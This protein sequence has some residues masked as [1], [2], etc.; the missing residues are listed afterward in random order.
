VIVDTISNSSE[1]EVRLGSLFLRLAETLEPGFDLADY[2]QMLVDE[3]VGLLPADEAAL[4]LGDSSSQLGVAAATAP[5]ARAVETLVLEHGSSPCH[6]AFIK[7]VP[8]GVHD[9]SDAKE[10]WGGFARVLDAAGF[11]AVHAVPMQIRDTTIGVVSMFSRLPYTPS[12]VDAKI[13]AMIARAAAIAL[14]QARAAADHAALTDQLQQAL[15]SRV[16]IEQAKGVVA[17][18]RDVNMDAAF[19]LIRE[20]A[21]SHGESLRDVSQRIIERTLAI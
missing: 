15:N 8:T 7:G 14:V 5:D 16:L 3:T 2:L 21:R 13:A 1:R 17:H 19:G 11:R 4:F 9:I 6:D 10:E 20:R 12:D 18:T